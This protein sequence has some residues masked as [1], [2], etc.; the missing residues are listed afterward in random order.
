MFQSTQ[1]IKHILFDVDQTLY[2]ASSGMED[3]MIRRMNIFTAGF[4]GITDGEAASMR[5]Q[6][7]KGYDSTLDWLRR[8]KGLTD[9]DA[10]FRDV[11]PV[12]FENFFPV[13]QELRRMLSA[14]KVPCSILTNSWKTHAVNLLD[15][16]EIREYFPFIFDLVFNNFKGKPNLSAY[17]NVLSFLGLDAS[18]VLYIDDVPRFVDAFNSIGGNV[19][20]V[21]ERLEYNSS[22]HKRVR[23]IT[24]IEPVL[25]EYDLL[26]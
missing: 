11:H 8:G 4:L 19:I 2:P 16:L 12:D 21:D 3:E 5:A 20:L 14:V 6:R 10:F 24:E 26:K 22:P 18:E 7:D 15:Y 1:M 17:S 25:R 23:L 13:N 9:T